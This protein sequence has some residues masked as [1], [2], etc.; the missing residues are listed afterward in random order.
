[1][2][3]KRE[4]KQ[5]ERDLSGLFLAGKMGSIVTLVERSLFPYARICLPKLLLRREGGGDVCVAKRPSPHRGMKRKKKYDGCD[6]RQKESVS[7]GS[8]I[9]CVKKEGTCTYIP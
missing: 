7:P 5:K 3:R 6:W 9:Y 1:M 8:E 4:R 2:A